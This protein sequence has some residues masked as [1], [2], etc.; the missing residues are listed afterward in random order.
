MYMC[1]IFVYGTLN[2]GVQWCTLKYM[3][4][5]G[6]LLGV[7]MYTCICIC[8]HVY[9]YVGLKSSCTMMSHILIR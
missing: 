6:T 2:I 4:I 9:V 7:Y 1:L 8:I 5:F 3:K